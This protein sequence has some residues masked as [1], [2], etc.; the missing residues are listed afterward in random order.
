MLKILPMI[1]YYNELRCK[2]LFSPKISKYTPKL[3]RELYYTAESRSNHSN[4]NAFG[5]KLGFRF[6]PRS[7]RTP[8]GNSTK[9]Y[10]IAGH[11]NIIRGGYSRMF[12][13]H[14]RNQPLQAQ[15]SRHY[16]LKSPGKDQMTGTRNKR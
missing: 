13:L 11:K 6:K 5:H 15:L 1:L 4:N 12:I 3:A 2:V 8:R 7:I 10:V 14:G 16:R 9:Q